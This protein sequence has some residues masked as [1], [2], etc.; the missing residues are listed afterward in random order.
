[1][2]LS[3]FTLLARW[4]SFPLDAKLAD[5]SPPHVSRLRAVRAQALVSPAAREELAEGWSRL[6]EV[7]RARAHGS[8]RARVVPPRERLAAAQ[9][10]IQQLVARLRSPA[11]VAA[12]GV[13]AANLLLCDGTGPLYNPRCQDDLRAAL[14]HAVGWMD[15][16]LAE[17]QLAPPRAR[18]D[19]AHAPH[20]AS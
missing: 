16:G 3:L 19:I 10:Q 12:R 2:H 17:R 5:G 6:V 11:P 4:L 1:M 15:G 18:L 9:P 20:L 14:M 13:A 7:T 8:A